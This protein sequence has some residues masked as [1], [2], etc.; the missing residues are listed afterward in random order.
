MAE[1]KGFEP[2]HQFP[3][4]R[5]FESRLFDHLST[6]PGTSA[7]YQ[8][9]WKK[10]S[11]FRQFDNR[12]HFFTDQIVILPAMGDPAMGAI[13]DALFCVAEIAAAFVPQGIQRT[14][15][16]QTAEGL[17]VRTG[18]AGKILALLVLEK[19]IMWHIIPPSR[20]KLPAVLW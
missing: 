20:D 11:L 1:E 18:M 16:E 7:L 12:G 2:L 3:G 19:V 13:L 10:S 4:L 9:H 17:R 5:D 14:I 6:P 8:P 15:A